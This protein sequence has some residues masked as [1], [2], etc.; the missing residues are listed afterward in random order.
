MILAQCQQS[1]AARGC[2]AQPN[3][4]VQPVHILS[5]DWETVRRKDAS[6][7]AVM[8]SALARTSLLHASGPTL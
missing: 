1:K 6:S 3:R 4:V 5:R 2:L 8:L 7:A